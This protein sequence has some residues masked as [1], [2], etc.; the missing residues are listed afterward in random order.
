MTN[1]TR[2]SRRRATDGI[3]AYAIDGAAPLEAV[4][5]SNEGELREIVGGADQEGVAVFPWG[6]GTRMAV[7]NPPARQG[8]VISTTALNRMV[9]HNAGDMTATFQAGATMSM[10]SE[11]LARD[12]QMLAIDPP[13]PARAT[14]GGTLAAGVSGPS[15][16]RFGHPRDTVIGMKVVQPNG[17]VSKSGGQVVKNVSGYDMSRLHIGGFGS[18]GVILEASFKLTPIPMYESAVLARFETIERA[19]GCAMSI[20]N[21]HVAPLALTAFGDS[22]ARR[23]DVDERRGVFVAVRLGGR[24]RTLDR[25]VDEIVAICRQ[26]EAARMDKLDGGRDAR[27]WRSLADFGWNDASPP[28]LNIRVNAL[29]SKLAE[30]CRRIERADCALE[31]CIVAQPGFGALEANWFETADEPPAADELQAIAKAARKAAVDAGGHAIIQRCPVEAKRGLDVWGGEP[32][33]IEVMR[34]LKRQYDPN[35]TLNP[36]R[37]VGGI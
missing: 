33:G 29:P 4:E 24:P 9:S 25:Q 26:S 16:W 17:V 36:G 35:D 22:T 3:A 6:G 1:P 10:I 23:I 5:P 20:Y 18:L 15:M 2:I 30:V 19:M 27:L 13:M 14:V 28:V 34:R 31:L 7:G 8:I 21:S 12:G 37:F 11:T 32:S